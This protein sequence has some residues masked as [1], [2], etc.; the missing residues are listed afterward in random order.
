[1]TEF[2]HSGIKFRRVFA[3]FPVKRTKR[4]QCGAYDGWAWLTFV[5]QSLLERTGEWIHFTDIEDVHLG[6]R[7]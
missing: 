1:M 7:E 2:V 5:N 4:Y 3:W 6:E